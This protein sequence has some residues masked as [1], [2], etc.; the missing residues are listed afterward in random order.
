MGPA[1]REPDTNT[2]SGRCA[3]RLRA[4]REK[5][6][7][8][9]EDVATACDCTTRTIYKWEAGHTYPVTKMLPTLAKLYGLKSPRA[10]LAEK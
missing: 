5:H 10:I 7:L 3:V 6:G 1:R 2:Y 8:S 9:V 4:L